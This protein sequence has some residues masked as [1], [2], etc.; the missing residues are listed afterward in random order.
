[1]RIVFPEAPKKMRAMGELVGGERIFDVEE[2]LGWF[3]KLKVEKIEV[4]VETA[5]KAGNLVSLVVSAEG[6][7]GVKVTLVPKP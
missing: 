2:I 7:G 6:K 1:V 5:V 4:W 3:E